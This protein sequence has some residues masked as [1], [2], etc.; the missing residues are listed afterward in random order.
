MKRRVVAFS[1]GAVCLLV[2]LSACASGG[3]PNEV[4]TEADESAG[5]AEQAAEGTSAGSAEE[6]GAASPDS[7]SAETE[8]EAPE[9]DGSPREVTFD[10]ADGVTLGGTLF[11]LGDTAV[12][13]AHMFPTEHTS[14]HP[15]A[16]VAADQGY[17]ALAY[18][19]RGFGAS[20]GDQVIANIDQDVRAAYDFVK[21]RGAQRVVLIGA[22]MGG[23]ASI[24]VAAELGSGELTG[25]VVLSSPQE[26]QGLAVS[27]AELGTLTMPSLWLSARTDSVTPTL[28]GMYESAAGPDKSMWIFEGSGTHGTFI[29]GAP[30]D[31][32]DLER[33]LLEFLTTVAPVG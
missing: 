5:E 22:S 7:S 13:F 21:A 1:L 32:E 33:R 28:E 6:E 9:E 30:L 4:Q 29:F 20:G 16:Q 25:L 10:T 3:T 11:G 31:G 12:V 24:K 2:L 15:F 14:W 17:L 27:D 8:P 23:T 18:D 26:F 19:F